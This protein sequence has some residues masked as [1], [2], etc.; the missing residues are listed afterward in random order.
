[1]DCLIHKCIKISCSVPSSEKVL[2]GLFSEAFR[3][4]IFMPNILLGCRPQNGLLPESSLDLP[5]EN[6]MFISSGNT[7]KT[8][9]KPVEKTSGYQ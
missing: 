8:S 1:M 5:K 3:R 2:S 6:K 7:T 4:V 9:G